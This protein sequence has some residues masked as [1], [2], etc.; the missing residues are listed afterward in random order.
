MAL[1]LSRLRLRLLL[2]RGGLFG[3]ASLVGVFGLVGTGVEASQSEP[4]KEWEVVLDR[5]SWRVRAQQA[6]CTGS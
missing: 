2:K 4:G 3:L 6:P 1:P 5:C